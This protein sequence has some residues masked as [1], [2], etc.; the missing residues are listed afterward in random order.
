M[1]AAFPNQAVGSSRP[2]ASVDGQGGSVSFQ[3]VWEQDAAGHRHQPL[4][5]SAA[6]GLLNDLEKPQYQGLLNQT[7]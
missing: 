2:A 4:R 5:S 6:M 3:A 7:T 1:L